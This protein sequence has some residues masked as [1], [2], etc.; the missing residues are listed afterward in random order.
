MQSGVTY[1]E[2]EKERERESSMGLA[3]ARQSSK[4]QFSSQ[5]PNL[6]EANKKSRSSNRQTDNV[7]A[8][9]RQTDRHTDTHAP[10]RRR[11]LGVLSVML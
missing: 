7:T 3:A 1:R 8:T 2:R 6:S 11:L 4:P 9:H 10:A 5:I